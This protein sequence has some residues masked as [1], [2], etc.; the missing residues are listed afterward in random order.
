M[1]VSL[2]S[3]APAG[4]SVTL[5]NLTGTGLSA[6][7]VQSLLARRDIPVALTF[8]INGVTYRIII[9]AGAD[10]ASLTGADGSISFAS[11]GQAF[12]MASV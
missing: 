4:G 11:L 9:P 6:A 10:I 2:V 5:P 7:L 3:S 8:M 12:G 1:A